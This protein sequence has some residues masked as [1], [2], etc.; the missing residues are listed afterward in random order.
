MTGSNNMTFG[1]KPA[2]LKLQRLREVLA[3]GP[4]SAFQIAEA[5]HLSHE[6]ASNY[7]HELKRRD[8]I[9]I[10][11]WSSEAREGK[12][13][14]LRAIYALG[15]GK[16][17]RKPHSDSTTYQKRWLENLKEDPE[18]YERHLQR[19]RQ[20]YVKKTFKPR[21][22]VAAQWVFRERKGE[23]VDVRTKR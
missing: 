20:W 23:T 22:D 5:L 16:D 15:K 12:R 3:H 13:R 6:G 14:C 2:Q 21:P 10:A 18:A 17:A 1:R 9:H 7:I 11:R 8:E 4:L 19:K